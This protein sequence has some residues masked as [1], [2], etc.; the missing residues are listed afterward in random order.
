[1][2]TQ[3]LK[4]FTLENILNE[5]EFSRIKDFSYD[6][7]ENG[8][9]ENAVMFSR[10]LETAIK[11]AKPQ[12]EDESQSLRVCMLWMYK[13]RLFCF[14]KLTEQERMQFFG[15][16]LLNYIALDLG[17]LGE[18]SY[19]FSLF[20]TDDTI[21]D[22][23]KNYLRA[24]QENNTL[25]GDNVAFR[26]QGIQPTVAYWLKE[27]QAF[28]IKQNNLNSDKFA[29]SSFMNTDQM[30]KLLDADE[31]LVLQAL[32]VVFNFLLN[33]KTIEN[34]SESRSGNY[35]NTVKANIPEEVVYAEE[36]VSVVEKSVGTPVKPLV[37]GISSQKT[38]VETAPIAETVGT[39]PVQPVI[40]KPK[41]PIAMKP[42]P[43]VYGTK[44]AN[45]QELLKRQSQKETPS[46]GGIK[47]APRETQVA[48]TSKPVAEIKQ[49]DAPKVV[50]I[51]QK[52]ETKPT[53]DIEKK[54]DMLRNKIE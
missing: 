8:D 2:A 37:S 3:K 48:T 41:Q 1:M 31:K 24:V 30:V 43:Q 46:L 11:V 39:L 45:I 5:A 47:N 18:L 49:N 27:Y 53:V 25:L 35:V 6:L 38:V 10:A 15:K 44:S 36:E 42:L 33:V 16:E 17:V 26:Q 54:L 22:I 28:K 32:L 29:I 23:A 21:K 52:E 12:N 51:Q 40:A 19:F 20:S 7:I 14:T 34:V 13:L 9:K 4:E 50:P